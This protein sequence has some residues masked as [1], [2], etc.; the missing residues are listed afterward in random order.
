MSSDFPGESITAGDF[1]QFFEI[2]EDTI[3]HFKISSQ[4]TFVDIPTQLELV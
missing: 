3:T 1:M 4:Q 2:G